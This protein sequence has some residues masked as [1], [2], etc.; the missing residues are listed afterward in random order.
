MSLRVL[1]S[2]VGGAIRYRWYLV[3][4]AIVVTLLAFLPIPR[5]PLALG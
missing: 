1:N 2:R 3:P 5:Q 4:V